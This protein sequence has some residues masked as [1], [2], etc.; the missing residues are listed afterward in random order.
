MNLR[1]VEKRDGRLVPFDE[2]KI[3]LAILAAMAAVG[4][5]D[6]AFAGEVAGIVRMTLERREEVAGA[7]PT[8]AGRGP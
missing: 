7:P 5:D 6:P 4:E 3:R 2:E 8:S 1:Q